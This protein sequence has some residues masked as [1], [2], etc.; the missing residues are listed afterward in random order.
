MHQ[1]EGGMTPLWQQAYGLVLAAALRE[2]AAS[3][4][5]IEEA[6]E[7]VFGRQWSEIKL[8]LAEGHTP[9]TEPVTIEWPRDATQALMAAHQ[10]TADQDDARRQTLMSLARLD[11]EAAERIT[12]A[13]PAYDLVALMRALKGDSHGARAAVMRGMQSAEDDAER[14]RLHQTLR[15]NASGWD[16][17]MG[18]PTPLALR[19]S[20]LSTPSPEAV[21]H[22]AT[23]QAAEIDIDLDVQRFTRRIEQVVAHHFMRARQRLP[24]FMDLHYVQLGPLWVKRVHSP[25]DVVGHG[26]AGVAQL[27]QAVGIPREETADSLRPMVLE[28][29]VGVDALERQLVKV[30]DAEAQRIDEALRHLG[31]LRRRSW[32]PAEDRLTWIRCL[33]SMSR[34]THH[35]LSAEAQQRLSTTARQV[36]SVMTQGPVP[37]SDLLSVR[38]GRRSVRDAAGFCAEL[39]HPLVD[40]CPWVSGQG[41]LRRLEARLYDAEAVLTDHHTALI[42]DAVRMYS[43]AEQVLHTIAEVVRT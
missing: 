23:Q 31:A 34:S 7:A 2:G 18:P 39:W 21:E 12:E 1:I 35:G 38:Q 17:L 10:A 24:S 41:T 9:L 29:L 28:R 20:A 4:A 11:L 6:C 15:W 36:A 42:S 3:Q 37:S 16:P 25:A 19:P 26:R 40:D 43:A 32:D 33:Q 30:Y 8:D 22:A 27:R 5:A 14:D 13:Y